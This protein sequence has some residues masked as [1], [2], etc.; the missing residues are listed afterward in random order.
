MIKYTRTVDYT[1][2]SFE[3]IKKEFTVGVG[4]TLYTK[5]ESE[6]IMSDVWEYITSAYYWNSNTSSIVKHMLDGS[7][8]VTIDGN[9]ESIE[10]EY[11][12]ASFKRHFDTCMGAAQSEAKD[13]TVK[14]RVVKVV[15]GR[16]GQGTVGKVVVAIE[17]PYSAGW[18]TL[19]EY[20]L[21]I[22]LDDVMT[23]YTA[24]N[25]KQYPTHKNILWVW[26]RNCEV[27]APVV[28]SDY[29]K[30]LATSRAKEGFNSLRAEV[31]RYHREHRGVAIAA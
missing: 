12:A 3:P 2:D 5:T 7:A 1:P 28:D 31:G 17:R 10:A 22:A 23:T 29:V 26:A 19:L 24:K 8:E 20:K 15:R 21:G 6:R 25:G 16:T 27:V 11:L 14:G 4:T 13:V 9:L 30:T 18:R